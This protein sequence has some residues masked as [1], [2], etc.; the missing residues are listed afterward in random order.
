MAS[1]SRANNFSKYDWAI[2]KDPELS[3][4]NYSEDL[5]I[6]KFILSPWGNGIDT[7][8]IWET[9]YSGSI[10]V[11]KRHPTFSML[12]G[13]PIY[14]YDELEDITISNLLNFSYDNQVFDVNLLNL[15]SWMNKISE[16]R[17]NSNHQNYKLKLNLDKFNTLNIAGYIEF[18]KIQD[19]KNP[20]PRFW[21]DHYKV[22]ILKLKDINKL[23]SKIKNDKN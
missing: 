22:P 17:L 7:H 9:L 10:P 23:L 16:T 18:D 19:Y 15:N 6:Y 2:T 21:G 5:S 8:R 13:L 11:V 4:S 3:N 14:F 1:K 20:E 12:E